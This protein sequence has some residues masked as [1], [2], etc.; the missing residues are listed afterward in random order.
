[1][2]IFLIGDQ[3]RNVFNESVDCD[4]DGIK[5][6][7]RRYDPHTDKIEGIFVDGGFNVFSLYNNNGDFFCE[8]FS[9]AQD[10]LRWL[11]ND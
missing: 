8:N 11:L 10:A 1:M 5:L 7:V 9:N 2:S 4:V 6:I 3:A